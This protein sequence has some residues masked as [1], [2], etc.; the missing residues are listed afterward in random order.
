MQN[1]FTLE[2]QDVHRPAVGFT[3]VDSIAGEVWKYGGGT[4]SVAIAALI[5]LGKLP[6]PDVAVIA[7]TGR[8]RSTTWQYMDTVVSPA[9]RRVGVEIHRV[10]IDAYSYTHDG[11]YSGKTLLIPAF[12]DVTGN[13][14]KM[15]GYCNRWWK[16]DVVNNWLR[17]ERGLAPSKVRS[18]IGF[19]ADEMP[20]VIRMMAGK[21]YQEGRIRFPLVELHMKRRDSIRLAEEMGWPTP[22]RSACWMC[23]NQTDAEWRDLKENHPAEFALAVQ[24]EREMRERD[25]NYWLHDSCQRIDTV[26][27]TRPDDLFMRACDPKDGAACFT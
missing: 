25:P 9:L 24:T 6:K 10:K 18:W 15:S 20:R 27:F 11:V 4:Q 19:S 5:V 12:T 3:K 22:P 1:E 21:E 7:D 14:G 13:K 17:R 26:D 16:Q 2:A 23:P 8:E